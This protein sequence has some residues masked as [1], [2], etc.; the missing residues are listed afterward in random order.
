VAG[1]VARKITGSEQ[2]F[3]IRPE[4]IHVGSTEQAP[5]TDMH[6]V[7]GVVREVVYV[8]LFTRYQVEIDGGSELVVVSQNLRTTSM[9]VLT[10]RGQRVRLSW[11][12]D[13]ISALPV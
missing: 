12:K 10:A 7:D 8:G 11:H 3:S 5:G 9:D 4:K 2:T 1:E 13:H 6:T